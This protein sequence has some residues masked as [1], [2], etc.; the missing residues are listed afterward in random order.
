[1]AKRDEYSRTW[2]KDKGIPIVEQYGQQLTVRALY[3]RLVADFGMTN[4]IQHYKR[5]GEAMVEA[6]WQGLIPFES[7]VDHGR[8]VVGSTEADVTNVDSYIEYGKGQI[9]GWMDNFSKNRWENQPIYP[10]VFIEKQALQGVFEIPCRQLSVALSACKGYPS[11]TFLNDAAKRF[12]EMQGQ[13]KQCIM[14]YFGDHDP[15]GDDIPRVIGATL[16]RMGCDI[17]IQ[18]IALTKK[19]AITMK[20]P[21]APVKRTDSR[22]AKWN[23][24]GQVELDAIEPRKLQDMTTKAINKLFDENLYGDLMDQEEIESEKYVAELKEYVANL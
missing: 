16:L 17:E 11:L 8:T 2:I 5:V 4:S 15:S 22:T 10:E 21:P 6:R 9:L 1:M 24:I 7:F 12:T 19:Q 23:G 20:L 18:R 13:G 3:Y 14:L